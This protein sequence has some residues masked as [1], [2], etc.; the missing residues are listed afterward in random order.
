MPKRTVYLS[1]GS[2]V[3]DRQ[4]NL[5]RAIGLLEQWH[6]SVGKRSSIYETEPQ[7]V[8]VQPWF[9]NLAIECE[10][11]VD[12]L[13][14]LSILQG[15]EHEAGRTRGAGEAPRGPRVIDI[16]VLLYGDSIM[17]LP[18]LTIPHCRMLERRFVLEPLEEIAPQLQDPRTGK[19]F[20]DYLPAIVGQKARKLSS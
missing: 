6:I 1:L 11:Q 7:D 13:Q 17:D 16:D 2:N 9:L 20:R 3:G 8:L 19:L 12:P 4:A 15:I 10:T 14:L 18:Q 5:E